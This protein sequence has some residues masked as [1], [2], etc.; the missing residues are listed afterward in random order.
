MRSWDRWDGA[1]RLLAVVL[2]LAAVPLAIWVGSATSAA[3]RADTRR[4]VT[5]DAT[6]TGGP[7]LV[8]SA[9]GAQPADYW[10][11]PVRW[12]FGGRS[13]AGLIDAGP[14]ARMGD[15]IALSVGADGQPTATPPSAAADGIDRGLMVLSGISAVAMLLVVTTHWLMNRRRN[16]DWDRAWRNLTRT[17]QGR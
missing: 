9:S 11:V 6:V 4:P 16:A 10:Q 5:V 8:A 15:R 7:V 3:D 14:G 12:K 2:V 1:V 13:R 17:R